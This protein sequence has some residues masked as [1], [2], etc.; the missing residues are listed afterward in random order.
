MATYIAANHE[1]ER[2]RKVVTMAVPHAA[3]VAGGFLTYDQLQRSW[4]MFFFQHPLADM[5]V[6]MD[7]LSFI[8]RL[9]ADWSPGS[10]A[11][12]NL[13]PGPDCLPRPPHLSAAPAPHPAPR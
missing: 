10:D 3:A 6:P 9:W 2:W 4:Y 7:D 8:Y 1:P 5:V 13:P 12:D 11:S